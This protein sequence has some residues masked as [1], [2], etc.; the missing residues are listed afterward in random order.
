MSQNDIGNLSLGLSSSLQT[1]Y[2]EDIE[3]SLA[4]ICE[5]KRA[6][7]NVFG[8]SRTANNVSQLCDHFQNAIASID[9]RRNDDSLTIAFVGAT[10][11]GKSWLIRNWVDD[12]SIRASLPSGDSQT[13]ATR[14]I[15]WV[16]TKPPRDLDSRTEKYLHCH[17]EHLRSLGTPYVLV[18]TPG[19]TDL[20]PHTA[21]IARR[22]IEMASVIVL[23]VRRQQ[24]RSEVPARLAEVGDGTLIVP[25]VTAIRTQMDEPSLRSDV[26]AMIQQLRKVA[27]NSE[28]LDVQL[29]QDFDVTNEAENEVG[30]K[31]IEEIA[32]KLRNHLQLGDYHSR[33]RSTRLES[34]HQRFLNDLQRTLDESG[35]PLAEAIKRIETAI[36]QL[37]H[38]IALQLIGSGHV[39][40]AAIRGRLRAEMM[41]GTPAIWFPYRTLLS[42]LSITQGAWDRVILAL[43]GSLPSLIGA[44]WTSVRRWQE[45]NVQHDARMHSL[46]D[47]CQTLIREK[48][49]PIVEHFHRELGNYRGDSP[50]VPERRDAL[51][52]TS[53]R[54]VGLENLQI[55]AQDAFE[56][57]VVDSAPRY[58]TLQGIAITA[59]GVFWGLLFA[60]I[61]ALYSTYFSASYETLV[62]KTTN[63][64]AFPH[65]TAGMLFT[66]VLLSLLPTAIIAMLFLTWAQRRSHQE[67]TAQEVETNIAQTIDRLQ[68]E[69]VLRLEFH[70]SM[71]E[72]A[73]CL[74]RFAK[75]AD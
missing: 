47:Y 66:S 50:S 16:G 10:G 32:E 7:R 14:H 17:N 23:V 35:T 5:V 13:E 33:R 18:D 39:L 46:Q 73:R 27:P 8:N 60:P 22:A 68:R 74:I 71:L 67:L 75:A 40:R 44:A 25:V 63:L 58:W 28:V 19:A 65:P 55:S 42:V 9:S 3:E 57:K 64:D 69:G 41:V 29:I 36:E 53:I 51:D 20:D 26:D 2:A 72:D 11:Q 37:P 15:V 21:A 38:E 1:S 30:S 70:D 56:K 43:S 34:L 49:F 31:A 61:L 6:G 62:E 12:P 54:L 52:P 48:I 4:L 59:S 24:L 45:E